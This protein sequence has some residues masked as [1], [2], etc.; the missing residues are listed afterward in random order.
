M[1]IKVAWRNV[2]RNLTRSGVVMLAVSLGLWAGIFLAA[3]M[4]GI[5]EQRLKGVVESQTSHIQI[6]HPEFLDNYDVAL[7]MPDGDA[8][9]E[10]IKR[11]EKVLGVSG[12]IV[13]QGMVSS[14]RNSSGVM[15][16]GVVPEDEKLVTNLAS[17]ISGGDFFETAGRNQVVIGKKLAEDLGVKLKSK[18]VLTFQDS[19]DNIASGAFRICGIF[20]TNSS[21]FD[22]TTVYVRSAD[23]AS[24]KLLNMEGSLHEIAMVTKTEEQVD[25][26]KSELVVALPA[27]K[28]ESW[29][30]LIPELY[31]LD[32]IMDVYLLI[33]MGIILLAMAFG[34]INSMLMAVLERIK[35]LGMLM[36]V[37]MT[38]RKIFGM[39]VIETVFLTLVGTPLGLAL[40]YFSV[41]YFNHNGLDLSLF[42]AGLNNFDLDSV[43]YPSLD[44]SFY[45]E[46]VVMVVITAILSAIYPAIKALQLRPAEAIRSM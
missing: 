41:G 4:Y 3:F 24:S 30:D 38:K 12:R 20:K 43:L 6:H 25:S 21:I 1:I 19:S 32:S 35:E 8:V 42:A 36:S 39:I 11:N 34:I 18:I 15:V 9:V 31:Y 14:P 2:W 13:V 28:V 5:S 7:L 40:G 22:G 45:P 33:F 16:R 29:K 17:K 26:V 27:K 10:N 37:G 44:S 23:I 46:L